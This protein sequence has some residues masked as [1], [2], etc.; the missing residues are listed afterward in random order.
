MY[1]Y[2]QPDVHGACLWSSLLCEER[3]VRPALQELHGWR[4]FQNCDS[5]SCYFQNCEGQE[6][7]GLNT[8]H[9]GKL[10]VSSKG[11]YQGK[12]FKNNFSHC[13]LFQCL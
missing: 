7:S 12:T 5:Q 3:L 13:P 6:I 11:L 8:N 1:Q 10:G 4:Q 9:L 2:L